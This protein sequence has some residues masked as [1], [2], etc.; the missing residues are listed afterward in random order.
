MADPR[1][2][3]KC[4]PSAVFSARLK[5]WRKVHHLLLKQVAPELGVSVA[6]FDA[7]ENGRR[8]P[9]GS[10]LDRIVQLTGMPAC[11]LFCRMSESGEQCPYRVS[12]AKQSS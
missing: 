10:H 12:D 7:W 4:L 6:T 3:E 11:M 2:V 1:L 9:S 8:F 5:Q